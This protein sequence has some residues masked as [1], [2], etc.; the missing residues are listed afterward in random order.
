MMNHEFAP[1][2]QKYKPY[3]SN[4]LNDWIIAVLEGKDRLK[5]HH[6]IIHEFL[7]LMEK[8]FYFLKLGKCAFERLEVEFLC[9]LVTNEGIIVDLSKA[10]R[11][12]K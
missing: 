2:I 8:L 9:W 3:L 6:C 11:L 5:L 1:L 7:D 4:Y 12:A 10:A